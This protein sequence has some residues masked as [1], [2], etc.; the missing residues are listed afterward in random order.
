MKTATQ[1]Q[2]EM[3]ALQ[4]EISTNKDLTKPQRTRIRKRYQFLNLCKTYIQGEPTKEYLQKEKD[5]LNNKVNLI[6]AGY[7]P[8]QRLIDACLKKEE[9]KEHKD[10]NKI[11][12]L[13]KFK[14]QLRSIQ[15]LLS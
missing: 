1:I 4:V 2:K 10:Y 13:A 7:I 6:N 14:D 8:D 15:F 12:G 3:D 9:Q 5:R 11:M